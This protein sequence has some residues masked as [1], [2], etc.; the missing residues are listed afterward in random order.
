MVIFL[1]GNKYQLCGPEINAT[2][3]YV[4]GFHLLILFFN[5]FVSVFTCD[6]DL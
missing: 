1:L 6:I 4:S 5:I 3:P 2:S